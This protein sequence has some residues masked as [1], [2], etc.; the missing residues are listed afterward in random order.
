MNAVT[1]VKE[2]SAGEASVAAASASK[3]L[4]ALHEVMGKVGYVQK[5]GKNEYQGYKYAGEGNLLEILRPAMVEAG[6]LLIPSHRTVSQIDQYGITTVCVEYTLAHK[7][8]EVWPEKIVAYGTGG[9]KNKNGVGDKGLYKAATG[10]NK[11]LLFKLFQI[12]TGD[13]PEK[14]SEHDKDGGSAGEV[15]SITQAQ[16]NEL[17]GLLKETGR[18]QAK[19]LQW[20]GADHIAN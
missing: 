18:D 14:D 2:G 3:I 5:K 17:A 15:L 1:K 13:D 10:A 19:F 7:D 16:A 8:G 11:Y 9:D 6:L 4:R 20:I 12:E